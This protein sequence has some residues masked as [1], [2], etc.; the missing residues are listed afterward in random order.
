MEFELKISPEKFRFTN[1]IWNELKLNSPQSVGYVAALIESKDFKDKE[2]WE[3]FYYNSG[4]NRI[5]ILK[6]LSIGNNVDN[7][8]TGYG[9]TKNE[10]YEKGV[11]L[12]NAIKSNNPLDLTIKDCVECVR[13]RVICETWNGVVIREKN[14]IKS[15]EES[16]P[17]LVFKK[18]S[19][20]IDY[21]YAIDYE[22]FLNGELVLG[23]QIKPKSYLGSASYIKKAKDVNKYKNEKYFNKFGVNVIDVISDTKGNIYDNNIYDYCDKLCKV[24]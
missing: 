13:Y 1:S 20:D 12:Y 23:I 14:T 6:N 15:L 9:R 17:E 18:V 19:G 10:L 22:V 24:I 21:E 2:E 3:E 4:E 7:F 11:T 8:N 16:Y 5:N